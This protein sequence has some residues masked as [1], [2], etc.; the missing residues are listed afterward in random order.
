MGELIAEIRSAARASRCHAADLLADVELDR[1]ICTI[2]E[3]QVATGWRLL[4]PS[5]IL[6]SSDIADLLNAGLDRRI[7]QVRP[8]ISSEA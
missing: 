5:V 3:A 8:S 4:P 7:G 6:M 1:L 2:M